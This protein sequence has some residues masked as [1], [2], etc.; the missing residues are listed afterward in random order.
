MSLS[1]TLLQ[2]GKCKSCSVKAL[3]LCVDMACPQIMMFLAPFPINNL[4]T[5]QL[6]LLN[7]E[8]ESCVGF[9]ICVKWCEPPWW[10]NKLMHF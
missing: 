10:A 9:K 6:G 2:G 3:M 4:L 7:N 8:N 5:T 1:L